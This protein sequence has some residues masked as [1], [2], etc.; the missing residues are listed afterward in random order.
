M[1]ANLLER[2]QTINVQQEKSKFDE[3]IESLYRTYYY[4][5]KQQGLLDL[6]RGRS[7]LKAD[8]PEHKQ[9]TVITSRHDPFSDVGLLKTF[10]DSNCKNLILYQQYH[11]LM[12]LEEQQEPLLKL[13]LQCMKVHE[14]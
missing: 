5:Y 10:D 13:L 7:D 12:A 2:A 14:V 11:P 6:L 4:H 3:E 9:T 8:I 1:Q